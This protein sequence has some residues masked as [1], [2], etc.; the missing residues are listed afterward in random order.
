MHYLGL[1]INI[2]IER[3]DGF[4]IVRIADDGI[5]IPDE[6]KEKIFE[7]NFIHGK[8]GKT[9]LGLYI[10]R[11]TMNKYNGSIYVEDNV[12]DGSVFILRFRNVV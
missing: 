8:S 3:E 6:V 1:R 4:C 12:P 11:E 10:A 9:G 5:G 7:E 2:K